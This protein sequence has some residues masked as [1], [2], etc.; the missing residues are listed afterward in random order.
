MGPVADLEPLRSKAVVET[1]TTRHR[2]V[3]EDSVDTVAAG[4]PFFLPS[5]E[6]GAPLGGGLGLLTDPLHP[7]PEVLGALEDRPLQQFLIAGAP[8]A[9]AHAVALQ[10]LG[11]DHE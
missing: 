5:H 11:Q 8:G 1:A 10:M 3:Q 4:A 2:A 7:G 6:R 9:H